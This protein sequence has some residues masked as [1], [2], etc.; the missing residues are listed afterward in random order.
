[1]FEKTPLG[2]SCEKVT[3]DMLPTS[4]ERI[5]HIP[6]TSIELLPGPFVCSLPSSSL[7]Y[8]LVKPMDDCV[9]TN[10]N[11]DLGLGY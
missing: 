9:T 4:L 11:D 2:R 8:P 3:V 5:G 6:R 7:E 10:L 1:M